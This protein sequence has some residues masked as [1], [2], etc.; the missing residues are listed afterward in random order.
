MHLDYRLASRSVTLRE[1][2][3]NRG[4]RTEVDEE[5]DL[6]RHLRRVERHRPSPNLEEPLRPCQP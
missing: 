2:C 5:T 1:H 3:L 6:S 4:S